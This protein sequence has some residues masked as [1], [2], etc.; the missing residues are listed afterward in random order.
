MYGDVNAQQIIAN[1]SNIQQGTNPSFTLSDFLLIYPQFANTNVPTAIAQMY[2]DLG[3]TVIQQARFKGSWKLA[4][5]YFI[6]HYCTIYL[7]TYSSVGD[8]K[9]TIASS[10]QSSGVITSESVDGV[11]YSLDANAVMSDLQGFAGFKSTE[12]GVQLAT[13]AK[14]YGKGGMGVW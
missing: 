8:G 14:M 1:A 3:L 7:K 4:I 10:G 12:F 11:S 9:D 13:L 5:S 2:L 6:A